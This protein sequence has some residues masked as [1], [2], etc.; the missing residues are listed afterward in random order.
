MKTNGRTEIIRELC[1]FERRVAG[2]DSERRAANW[3]A[4]RLRAAGRRAEVE[5]IHVHPQHAVVEAAHCA[6]GFAGSLIAIVEPAAGFALVLLAATSLYLDL[7]GRLYLLRSLFFRRASQNV[8]SPGPNPDAPARLILCAHYDAGRTGAVF[9]PRR[10]QR[11]AR[12]ARLIPAPAGGVRI[13]FWSLAAL[14]PLLGARM[15]GV[16]SNAIAI[17]QV[18]PTLVLLVGIF[19][20]VD[21]QLSDIIPGANDDASGVATALALAAELDAEP[22]A[23]LDVW[24]L[25]TGG[26]ECRQEGM[27]AFLRAHPRDLDPDRTLFVNFDAIGSGGLRYLT[28]A[29]WVVSFDLDRRMIELCGAIA[30]ADRDGENRFRAE[31][32]RLATADDS[33]P[34]RLRGYRSIGIACRDD[35]GL[36]PND[37][38]PADRPEAIDSDAL[39][40]AHDFALEL[41]RQIDRDVQRRAD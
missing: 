14:L 4:D 36:I 7:N 3:L 37:H 20:L 31:P 24:L 9:A 5:P 10:A 28:S 15:T 34:P 11:A 1:S 33:L 2:S 23:N 40:R 12:L 38:L 35:D 6:I 17:A 16:D 39:D 19:A 41:V 13:L 25:L 27:R 8:V 30:D 21:I 32:L 22:P 18:L 26:G 29:G